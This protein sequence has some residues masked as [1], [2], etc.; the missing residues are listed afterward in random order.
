MDPLP[1]G[2][3]KIE[4]VA[5][6][7]EQGG[8]AGV[9][10]HAADRVAAVLA[11]MAPRSNQELRPLL[12]TQARGARVTRFMPARDRT[13]QKPRHTNSRPGCFPER[14]VVEHSPPF[15]VLELA[16]GFLAMIGRAPVAITAAGDALVTD[17][18]SPYAALACLYDIDMGQILRDA[19]RV[20]GVAVVLC[21]D[22]HPLN[23]AHWL[24]DELPRLAF[25]GER[26]GVS[27][28]V[29]G[30]TPRWQAESLML[31][32]F[33]PRRLVWLED[34]TAVRADCLLVPRDLHAMPHPAHKAA[35]WVLD[36][37]RGRLGLAALAQQQGAAAPSK[38]YISRA[39]AEGRRVVNEAALLALLAP[40]GYRMVT[41]G[42]LKV[43]E[44]AALFARASHVVGLHGAGLANFAFAPAGAQLV[45]IFPDSYGTPAY[46]VLAAGQGNPYAS[47][48]ARSVP[49]AR[50]S[51]LDDV[52]VDIADFAACCVGLL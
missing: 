39:D 34:F 43:A 29:S 3:N 5:L 31:C 38:L 40:L 32:G 1:P 19:Q 36:F 42:G 18:S 35:P 14:A 27:I 45:E 11:G 21:D 41:L 24:L 10:P 22:V 49:S 23:Y 52:S 30:S 25:L 8:L 47:Y 16:R 12:A 48:V 20:E 13:L 7:A 4:A 37:L 50:R 15:E 26:R 17:F 9:D 2:L 44:Q 33:D 6:L 28:V 46:Y 51:Q